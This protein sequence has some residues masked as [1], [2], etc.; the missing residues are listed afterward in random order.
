MLLT[1]AAAALE[2]SQSTLCFKNLLQQPAKGSGR[3]NDMRWPRLPLL[4]W[5]AAE[6]KRNN[7]ESAAATSPLQLW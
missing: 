2:G 5:C 6:L 1:Q 4:L 7:A 3:M